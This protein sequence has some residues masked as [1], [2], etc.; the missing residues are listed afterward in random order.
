MTGKKTLPQAV[1]PTTA[2]VHEQP[3][4]HGNHEIMDSLVH[5]FMNKTVRV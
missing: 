2:P 1:P 5:E 4:N 3:L